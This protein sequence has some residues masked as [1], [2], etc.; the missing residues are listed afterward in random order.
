MKFVSP[1]NVYQD[2]RSKLKPTTGPHA[3]R[4]DPYQAQARLPLGAHHGPALLAGGVPK[5]TV[6]EKM[7]TTDRQLQLRAVIL[8]TLASRLRVQ[9]P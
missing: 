5:S 2:R 6:G 7:A 8:K 1:R 3:A 9:R 4:S